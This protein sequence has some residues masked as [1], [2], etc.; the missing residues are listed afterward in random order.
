[1]PNITEYIG[2]EVSWKTLESAFGNHMII[3][4]NMKFEAGHEN[5]MNYATLIP[6]RICELSEVVTDFT[7]D[8]I[9]QGIQFG[10]TY[11]GEECSIGCFI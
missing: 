2:K 1:M 6:L 5:D 7:A 8:L 4:K 11:T 9:K 3:Y 10:I